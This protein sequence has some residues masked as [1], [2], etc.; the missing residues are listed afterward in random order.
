MMTRHHL[1][2]YNETGE[3]YGESTDNLDWNSSPICP[4][5][6]GLTEYWEGQIDQ[7]RMGNDIHGW[8]WECRHCGIGTELREIEEP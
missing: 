7:D 3:P 6:G 2:S 5:C 8:M 4:K 1:W